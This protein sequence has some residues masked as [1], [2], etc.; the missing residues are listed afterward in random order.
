MRTITEHGAGSAAP[1]REA[2]LQEGALLHHFKKALFLS[3]GRALISRELVAC[4]VD[5]Y[6]PALALLKRILPPGMVRFLNLPK[7]S[8]V[9]FT[10]PATNQTPAAPP[11]PAAGTAGPL[12]PGVAVSSTTPE[13][14]QIP[15]VSNLSVTAQGAQS[16]PLNGSGHQQGSNTTPP[17]AMPVAGSSGGHT[18]DPLTGSKPAVDS[19]G[20][21]LPA[22]G[23]AQSPAQ[24]AAPTSLPPHRAMAPPGPMPAAT[25]PT[26]MPAATSGYKFNWDAF[27][28]AL[29]RMHEHAG[30]SSPFLS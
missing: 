24:P 23:P 13:K 26:A 12:L 14:A 22:V 3:E 28:D 1:M 20:A 7:Q 6:A 17:S 16:H 2:A 25:P 27:W 29:Q 18:S 30:Q 10:P 15:A 21:A 11:R 4:W 19:S 9:T 8:S 5:G